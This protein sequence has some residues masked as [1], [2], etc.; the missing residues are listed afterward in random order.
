MPAIKAEQHSL[1]FQAA[2]FSPGGR[3]HSFNK[4]GSCQT[5]ANSHKAYVSLET[6][7]LKTE[8]LHQALLWPVPFLCGKRS[9]AWLRSTFSGEPCG[10]ARLT[11]SLL[12]QSS[13]CTEQKWFTWVS[14]QGSCILKSDLA[15]CPLTCAMGRSLEQPMRSQGHLDDCFQVIEETIFFSTHAHPNQKAS[16]S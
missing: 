8:D 13:D 11:G 16:S 1:V 2:H 5:Q 15:R 6:C 10:V 4:P 7:F 3:R 12:P 9:R 14:S